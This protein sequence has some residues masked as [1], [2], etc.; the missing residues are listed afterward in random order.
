MSVALAGILMIGG[1]VGVA[2]VVIGVPILFVLMAID[3]RESKQTAPAQVRDTSLR[4]AAER[5][6]ARLFVVAGGL[7]WSVATFAGLYSFR[8]SGATASFIAAFLPAVACLATL[9]VGWYFERTTAT[10]LARR[11]DRH[12]RVGRHLSV[13]DG[14][15]D[16]HDARS[17]RPDAHRVPALLARPSRPGRLRA[18]DRYAAL[19]WRSCS[20]R[21][22]RSPDSTRLAYLEVPRAGVMPALSRARRLAGDRSRL[23]RTLTVPERAPNHRGCFASDTRT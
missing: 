3:V 19:S 18:R 11:R 12:R 20:P 10:L 2:V 22:A 21:A 15:V 9:I 6:I 23:H 16:H 7:F 1:L 13:R 8:D 4:I 14:R 5:G 17:H